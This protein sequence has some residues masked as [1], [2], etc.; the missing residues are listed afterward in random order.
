MFGHGE[1]RLCADFDDFFDS[2]ENEVFTF[3]MEYWNWYSVPEFLA[4]LNVDDTEF[5]P[6][7][8]PGGIKFTIVYT[9]PKTAFF[10]DLNYSVWNMGE[11]KGQTNCVF[12]DNILHSSL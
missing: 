11:Y 10:I 5:M 3:E 8:I 7:K 9:Q 1:N 4:A 12:L 2:S 6:P